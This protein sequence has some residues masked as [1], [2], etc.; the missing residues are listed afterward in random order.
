[1]TTNIRVVD[2][3]MTCSCSV[4]IQATKP[5]LRY[6]AAK[7]AT[8]TSHD[9]TWNYTRRLCIQRNKIAFIRLFYI[10]SVFIAISIQHSDFAE[11]HKI[12]HC[13]SKR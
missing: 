5:S 6:V 13:I 1:M 3:Y 11:S 2:V 8:S 4:R 12:K 9:I 7:L 10:H